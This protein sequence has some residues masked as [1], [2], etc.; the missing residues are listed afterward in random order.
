MPGPE[1]LFSALVALLAL[2]LG[3]TVL[4]RSRRDRV[5]RVFGSFSLL[6]TIW[7]GSIALGHLTTNATVGFYLERMVQEATGAIL[8]AALLHL[9]VA[10]ALGAR[11][12]G[13]QRDVVVAAYLIGAWVAAWALLNP[14]EPFHVGPPHFAPAGI[15]V[16]EV[17]PG[18]IAT[19]MT[20]NVKE[21]YDKRIADGL[22]PD[23]RWGQPED[24]G[25]VVASLLRGDIA[26]ATGTVFNVDGG[27][28]IPRL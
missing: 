23:R 27:L 20:A 17:R 22:V 19:D 21:A 13:W 28:S 2:W 18:I 25:R 7:A 15:P 10:F 9:V 26:Y 11:A 1:A 16:F 24:V 3:V 4:T 14:A 8:P 5:A 6:L 12:P